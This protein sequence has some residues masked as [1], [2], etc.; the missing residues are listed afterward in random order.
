MLA[1]REYLWVDLFS[2]W[3]CCACHRLCVQLAPCQAPEVLVTLC[4][5]PYRLTCQLP[6]GRC[7]CYSC[8]W[9]PGVLSLQLEGHQVPAE[10]LGSLILPQTDTA[11][12]VVSTAQGA[13]NSAVATLEFM[14]YNGLEALH[15]LFLTLLVLS[16]CPAP[17]PHPTPAPNCEHSLGS[18]GPV[19]TW[20]CCPRSC[21]GSRRCSLGPQSCS[22]AD[23]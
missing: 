4:S 6:W 22:F 11:L 10:Y 18:T 2:T 15:P 9:P 5:R 20:R 14:S 19:R 17:H 3:P 13:W 7:F 21:L 1:S 8:P 12:K 16:V 23:G